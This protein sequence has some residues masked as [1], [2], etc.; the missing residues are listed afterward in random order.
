MDCAEIAF[1]QDAGWNVEPR[2]SASPY[3]SERQKDTITDFETFP[4]RNLTHPD[5]QLSPSIT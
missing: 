3:Q 1:M 4:R 5:R 2:A